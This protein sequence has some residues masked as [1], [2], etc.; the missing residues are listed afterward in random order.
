MLKIYGK[1]LLLIRNMGKVALY[2]HYRSKKKINLKKLIN[3][4]REYS[5]VY[6]RVNVRVPSNASG[7]HAYFH[8]WNVR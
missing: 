3:L 8:R 2:G 1:K 4:R 6:L 7:R 5:L